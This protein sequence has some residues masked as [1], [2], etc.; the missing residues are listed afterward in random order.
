MYTS[1][2]NHSL[3]RYITISVLFQ[4][5]LQPHLFFWLHLIDWFIRQKT[6]ATQWNEMVFII[7][8]KA[9]CKVCRITLLADG[10]FNS[11]FDALHSCSSLLT[12]VK[13]YLWCFWPANLNSKFSSTLNSTLCTIRFFHYSKIAYTQSTWTRW[14]HVN[15][16]NKWFFSP[17][18]L[19]DLRHFSLLFLLCETCFSVGF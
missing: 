2:I 3:I 9:V 11:I 1:L 18:V 12:Y 7:I 6:V 5:N 15:R 13:T 10:L 8:N 19:Q 17:F 16:L 4:L 14:H